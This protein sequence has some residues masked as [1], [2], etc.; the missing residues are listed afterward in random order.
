MVD[1]SIIVPF[2]NEINQLA[3]L[4]SGIKNQ[5]TA[6]NYEVIILDS[7]DECQELQISQLNPFVRHLRILP[8]TFNHGK[9]RNIGVMH[10]KGKIIVF[11]VQ[12]AV[13]IGLNWLNDL[14]SPI[15]TKKI[16]AICGRQ[17]P[18]PN[19]DTNPVECYKPIDNPS[20]NIVNI[21]YKSFRN[22]TGSEK[23]KYV[24][25]DNVNSAYLKSSLINLPFREM[26]FGEDTQWAVDAISNNLTI[27]YTSFSGVYHYHRFNPD[28]NFNRQLSEYFI[29]FKTINLSPTTPTITIRTLISWIKTIILSTSNPFKISY[30]FI[31]NLRIH[32][33]SVKAFKQWHHS[34]FFEVE[35]YLLNNVPMSKK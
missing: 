30:W 34:G 4:L 8:D 19:E 28:F 14:V 27:A 33:T 20:L 1:V 16:H 9:T 17:M 35:K 5:N 3:K 11:T 10:A 2:R 24:G 25:W 23:L 22:L 15:F 21:S 31:Y 18:N 6:Y 29:R 26:I 32:K 7:S 13:P 12:D